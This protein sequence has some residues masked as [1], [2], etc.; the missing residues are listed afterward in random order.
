MW[1]LI[2][3]KHLTS[4]S[5]KEIC[6]FVILRF[7]IVEVVRPPSAGTKETPD[8]ALSADVLKARAAIFNA[9]PPEQYTPRNKVNAKPV[10]VARVSSIVNALFQCGC[11]LF[12]FCR[13]C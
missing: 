10:H 6:T 7:I 3:Q 8:Y 2:T 13:T 11:E 4:I 5:S 12:L 9:P 1:S